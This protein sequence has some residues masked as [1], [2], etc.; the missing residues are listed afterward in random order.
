MSNKKAPYSIAFSFSLDNKTLY[1]YGITGELVDTFIQITDNG[2]LG[3]EHAF[4]ISIPSLR[5]FKSNDLP[6]LAK[7]FI[8]NSYNI[9]INVVDYLNYILYGKI[10]NLEK[11][12]KATIMQ[13]PSLPLMGILD[14]NKYHKL[15]TVAVVKQYLVHHINYDTHEL[16]FYIFSTR[17]N[18][19]S[20]MFIALTQQTYNENITKKV[21]SYNTSPSVDALIKVENPSYKKE[22]HNYGFRLAKKYGQISNMP[23]NISLFYNRMNGVKNILEMFSSVNSTEIVENAKLTTLNAYYQTYQFA[24]V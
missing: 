1:I 13:A 19:P 5:M 17:N 2:A 22:N 15:K 23:H 11:E 3:Y 18:V 7:M 10:A 12:M 21:S 16:E 6:Y 9:N 14:Y 24:L 4:A 20:N 8:L